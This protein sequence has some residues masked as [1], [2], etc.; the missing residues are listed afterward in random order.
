[1]YPGGLVGAI[2]IGP[3]FP[4]SESHRVSFQEP[5]PPVHVFPITPFSEGSALPLKD[6]GPQGFR[7]QRQHVPQNLL[8]S[9]SCGL[10]IV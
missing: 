5:G 4:S 1:M 3:T 6:N 7:C 8:L 2:H 9:T 10:C